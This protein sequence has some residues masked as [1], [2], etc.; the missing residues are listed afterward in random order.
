[1]ISCQFIVFIFNLSGSNSPQLAAMRENDYPEIPRCLRWGG[2]FNGLSVNFPAIDLERLQEKDYPHHC[3][4]INT[5]RRTHMAKPNRKV[6]P[7]IE[8]LQKCPT[9]IKGL[10]SPDSSL[11]SDLSAPGINNS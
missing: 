2:S 3:Y 5:P 8:L 6:K 9:G 1:M 11:C 10:F 7:A 4:E